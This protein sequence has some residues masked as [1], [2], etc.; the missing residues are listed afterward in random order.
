MLSAVTPFRGGS[1]GACRPEPPA[2]RP[3]THS[4]PAARSAASPRPPRWR[5]CTSTS[6]RP[7]D[8]P[9]GS[10]GPGLLRGQGDRGLRKGQ[11]GTWDMSLPPPVKRRESA[12]SARSRDEGSHNAQEGRWRQAWPRISCSDS[13]VD[14]SLLHMGTPRLPKGAQQ[15][16]ARSWMGAE[17][18]PRAGQGLLGDQEA[19]PAVAV[20]GA[21]CWGCHLGSSVIQSARTR[22]WHLWGLELV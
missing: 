2:R 21:G 22:P 12:C 8:A 11:A 10:A 1:H 3:A 15:R 14:T 17:G 4:A 5:P 13:A 6:R 7:P 16:C 19:A 9:R 18:R 20:G